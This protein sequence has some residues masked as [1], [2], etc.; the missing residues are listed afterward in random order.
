LPGGWGT[1]MLRCVNIR[2]ASIAPILC[3][4]LV[5]S[6]AC[7]ESAPPASS[8][9]P[10]GRSDAAAAEPA[11]NAAASRAKAKAPAKRQDK[12]LPAF[13][14][15]TLEGERLSIASLIGKRLLLFF[16]NP[17]VPDAPIIADAVARISSLRGKQNFQI[18]GI[19]TGSKHQTAVDF[20]KQHGIDYPVLDDSQA[21][22]ANRLG[23]RQPLALLG[24]D[25]EGY[26]I[27]G[28]PAYAG[29]DKKAGI[30][31]ES[32]LRDALR[33]QP[34]DTGSEPV[35]GSR[36][37]AP[38]FSGEILDQEASFSLAD[39]RGEAVIVIFFLHTCPHCHQTLNFFKSALAELPADTRPTLVGVE[40]TGKT[41]AVRQSLRDE[42][43]EFFPVIFDVSGTIRESYGVFG[44]VPDTFFIDAE[45]RIAARVK[46][47]RADVDEHL[48]RMRMAKLAGAP[49]P[50][51]LRKTGFTGSDAC[52]VCHEL[53]HETWLFTQHAGAYDTLVKHGQT[54]DPECVSCH[55]VGF[56]QDGGFESAAPVAALEGVGCESCHG[57][58]GPHLSP[59]FVSDDNYA[60]ACASCHNPE[61]SLGFDYATFRPKISHAANAH[62]VNLS[63]AE[64]QQLLA[65]LGV[66][67]DV[68]PT[69]ADY[70][71][72][73]ACQGCHASEHA[74]W[75]ASPHARAVETL[76]AAGEDQNADCQK[77]HTT[78]FGRA[79][80][81]ASEA[82]ATSGA[83]LALVGCESCHGPGGN[84]VDGAAAKIGTIVSLGDKCDSCVILQ[85][86]GACHDDANDPGF[87][88]EVLEKIEKQRH[89]TI[90]AGT[91]KPLTK[92]ARN[93][94]WVSG[95]PTLL[96]AGNRQGADRAVGEAFELLQ[97]TR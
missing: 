56:G 8:S 44:A 62:V 87:E 70:V 24:V 38:A 65:E 53:E 47:W 7:G 54:G 86:C 45:G 41:S 57:R 46:G 73:S 61:H 77:C 32:Q 94:T 96:V 66:P 31:I 48:A 67:R 69:N 14:G 80:G 71:G 25:S 35:L 15:F 59:D 2:S 84:H 88:F 50:M 22:I 9:N 1:L 3:V 29:G 92:S 81:F 4:S 82:A 39:H 76:T 95:E 10:Q 60:T 21:A 52:G 55:V 89:G 93:D 20:A 16:F 90:E 17:E 97:R 18:V 23:L 49:I 11:K 79:G 51:L 72:S 58:G 40:I 12:P 6:L 83:D 36:P 43:L 74:T 78:G 19:A 33:L 27:F 91:G 5:V 37:S 68:L 28:V 85:I 42:D 30:A 13:S 63:V 34:I 75:A 64:R 26:V